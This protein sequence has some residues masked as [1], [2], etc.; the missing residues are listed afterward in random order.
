M[1]GLFSLLTP[2][3]T[4]QRSAW[5]GGERSIRSRDTGRQHPFCNAQ[6]RPEAHTECIVW[7]IYE[8]DVRTAHSGG[9]RRRLSIP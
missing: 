5:A 2:H 9:R 6:E 3:Q 1:P 7:P 8:R 4:G